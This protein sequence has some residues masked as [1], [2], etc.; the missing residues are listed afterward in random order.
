MPTYQCPSLTLPSPGSTRG[1]RGREGWGVGS[2]WPGISRILS[3]SPSRLVAAA[4]AKPSVLVGGVLVSRGRLVAHQ[5]RAGIE[6]ERFEAG[7]DDR[8]VLGRAA[9]HRRPAKEA[10]L[11][12]LGRGAVAV[13]LAAGLLGV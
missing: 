2:Q 6:G 9:H 1:S 3:P 8:A 5:R 13:E 7:I 10:L 12:G 11:E 4:T